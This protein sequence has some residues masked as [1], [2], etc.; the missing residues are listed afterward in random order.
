MG[1]THPKFISAVADHYRVLSRSC[2]ALANTLFVQTSPRSLG[3]NT[4]PRNVHP[5][6]RPRL[7]FLE[8][9][10]IME[11]KGKKYHG[12]LLLQWGGRMG[13]DGHPP[14]GS[15]CTSVPQHPPRGFARDI[16]TA[17]GGFLGGH[18]CSHGGQGGT[19]QTWILL[20]GAK[21][22]PECSDVWSHPSKMPYRGWCQKPVLTDDKEKAYSVMSFFLVGFCNKTANYKHCL[23]RGKEPNTSSEWCCD[24]W[25]AG[26]DA[27]GPTSALGNIINTRVT[28]TE[29]PVG[30]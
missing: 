12:R 24:P 28:L 1:I 17:L 7:P 16:G 13:C 5:P 29:F 8:N 15:L 10:L 6:P 3:A 4:S 26:L 9:E 18:P 30:N 11:S 25:S 23:C 19:F 22:W 2:S 21:K 14:A 20:E 27:P